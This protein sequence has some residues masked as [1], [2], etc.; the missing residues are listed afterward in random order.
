MAVFH[1]ADEPAETRW[2]CFYLL[3]VSEPQKAGSDSAAVP[4]SQMVSHLPVR[5][6]S[7]I[8]TVRMMLLDVWRIF[9]QSF[10]RMNQTLSFLKSA[11]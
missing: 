10:I 2:V 11:H 7:I 8:P 5:W 9:G 6:G 3:A 4:R 1:G